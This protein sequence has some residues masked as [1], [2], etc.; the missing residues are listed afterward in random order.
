MSAGFPI[1]A[2]L[3]IG[4]ALLAIGV[5]ATPAASRYRV[6]GLLLFMVLGM[7]VGDDGLG[8]VRFDDE[9]VAQNIAVVAL[10]VILF[11]GGLSAPGDRLRTALAPAS[12]LATVGVVITAAVVAFFAHHLA[13][14]SYGTAWIVGAVIASTDAAAVFSTLRGQALPPR[15][16]A[17]LQLESG[18]NDP[19]AV[20]LTVAAVEMWRADPA[21]SAWVLFGV[22]QLGGGLLVGL[23][24]G[25]A[26]RTAL[27]RVRLP[28]SS[29]YAVLALAIGGV[30]YGAAAVVGGSGFLAIYVCG[31]VLARKRRLVRPLRAFHEGLAGAAQGV[32]FLMLGLLV[33]PS[34][35]P[36]VA[37]HA[38][39]V[40]A[41]LVFVARPLAVALVLPWFR[42]GW[43]PVTLVSWAGLRGA[44]PVVLA[45]IPLTAGHPDGQFV[46]DVVFVVVVVSVA[47]QAPLIPWMVHRLGLE[48]P[49]AA[50]SHADL[51]PIDTMQADIVELRLSATAAV[52][53][54]TLATTPMPGGSRVAM[55]VR[56]D[57]GFVPEGGTVLQ[58]GDTLLVV[59]PP[60][61]DPA[62][63][64]A[65]AVGTTPPTSGALG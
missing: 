42:F 51:V 31:L 28:S 10:A 48:E 17:L 52:V 62:F 14:L 13:G 6:P 11:E 1:D 19:M 55:L 29:S 9:V 18:L 38:V 25:V 58:A 30:A 49:A 44:V 50:A 21:P 57:E 47:V 20:L 64:D 8:L 54:R 32:L 63:L 27:R 24:V 45:T 56:D 16:S 36:G 4:A 46:F 22:V 26:A 23:A 15:L 12:V 60:G 41:A 65:W 2:V 39:M 59:M 34:Q 5:A 40:A 43:R 33:F 53:G 3:L 7:V 61:C 35:L 37:W